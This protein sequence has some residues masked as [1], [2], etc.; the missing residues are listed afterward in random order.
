MCTQ[1]DIIYTSALE[2]G[3]IRRRTPLQGSGTSRP[4]DH[5][6]AHLLD[7]NLFCSD[8]AQGGAHLR[9]PDDWNEQGRSV[10]QDS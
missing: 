4:A 5:S 6:S 2:V 8:E 9:E 10:L 1:R 3:E 7:A